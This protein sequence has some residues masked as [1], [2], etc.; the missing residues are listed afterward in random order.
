MDKEPFRWTPELSPSGPLNI[1]VSKQDQAIVVM[2]NGVEIGRSVA[3]IDDDD[4]GTHVISVTRGADGKPH[5]VYMGLPGHD[6]DQGRE[7]DQAT[8][9]RVRVPKGFYQAVRPLVQ[10]GVTILVTQSSVG[11]DVTGRKLT[12]ID[13]VIPQP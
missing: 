9:E 11:E 2:R 6:A 7:L 4:P 5:F 13:A 12:V 1:V 3:Q 10:P 8:I